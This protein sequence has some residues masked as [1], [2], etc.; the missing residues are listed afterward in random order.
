MTVNGKITNLVSSGGVVY[1]RGQTGSL[2]VA[3]C[4]RLQSG[5][6]SLPKG[7]PEEGETIQQTALRE[8][9]EET[10]LEVSIEAELG[11]IEYQFSRS[12]GTERFHKR[13]YFYLMPTH[14]GSM[15]LHD[16]EFD[17]VK[18]VPMDEAPRTLTHMNEAQVIDRAAKALAE[19]RSAH[20]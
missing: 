20:E 15:D 14:G 11:H 13:V 5:T 4:G 3:L 9:Q 16:P 18:W 17:V 10:G 19:R 12:Q 2:E 8:V 7:T 6:W 1:R